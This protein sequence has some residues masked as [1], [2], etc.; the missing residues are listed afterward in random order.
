MKLP[1]NEKMK[2][3]KTELAVFPFAI[4]LQFH[5]QLFVAVL[6][7]V[8]LSFIA[9]SLSVHYIKLLWYSLN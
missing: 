7:R 4:W 6:S 1:G 5:K 2:K 8:A 9:T 3:G